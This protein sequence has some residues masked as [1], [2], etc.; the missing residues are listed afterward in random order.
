MK[1]SHGIKC[2]SAIQEHDTTEKIYC[3]KNKHEQN[4]IW[5]KCRSAT[6]KST[7]LHYFTVSNTDRTQLIPQI[8]VSL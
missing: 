3:T 7:L 6:Q 4:P 2:R 8:S 5:V 1:K